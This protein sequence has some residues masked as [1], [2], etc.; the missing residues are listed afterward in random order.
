MRAACELA[1]HIGASEE[2][3]MAGAARVFAL[4]SDAHLLA[5]SVAGFVRKMPP[6][7]QEQFRV[8]ARQALEAM[9][10]EKPKRSRKTKRNGEATEPGAEPATL[11]GPD[12]DR[13][14]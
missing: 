9:A 1:G 11:P 8:A 3:C 7:T 6:E 10:E 4:M 5:E 2:T 12:E 13:P 14:L